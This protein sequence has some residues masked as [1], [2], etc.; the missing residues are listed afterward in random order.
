MTRIDESDGS[1]HV[2]INERTDTGSGTNRLYQINPAASSATVQVADNDAST[3]RLAALPLDEAGAGS[4]T[5][6]ATTV[7]I[8]EG[9]DALFVVTATAAQSADAHRQPESRRCRP[10]HLDNTAAESSSGGHY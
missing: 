7:T 3:L 8:N 1:I 10:R 2:A 9:Q 4:G 6:A 5:S